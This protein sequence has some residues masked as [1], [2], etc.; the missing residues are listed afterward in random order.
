M[1]REKFQIRFTDGSVMTN[2][3][4]VVLDDL[5]E[6]RPGYYRAFWA[7]TPD[8]TRCCP[9]IGYASGGTHRTIRAVVEEVRRLYPD[10]KIYR[11]GRRI[12]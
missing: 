5:H 8:D 9:V 3:V 6:E 4:V 2:P 12:Y 7:Q 1:E 10:V 11:N